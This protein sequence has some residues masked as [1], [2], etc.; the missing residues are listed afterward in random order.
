[1][2]WWDT[3][4]RACFSPGL[5]IFPELLTQFH[6][7][8]TLLFPDTLISTVKFYE[9]AFSLAEKR[10]RQ[11]YYSAGSVGTGAGWP[12][13]KTRPGN[14]RV[15]FSVRS[16]P[17]SS[18]V[19]QG[20]SCLELAWSQRDEVSGGHFCPRLQV[21]LSIWHSFMKKWHY[22][23]RI[24]SFQLPNVINMPFSLQKI[25]GDCTIIAEDWTGQGPVAVP[26]KKGRKRA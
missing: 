11:H 24:R 17:P 9:C 15:T 2:S 5:T 21:F 22:C 7:K 12:F 20:V 23:F 16:S 1:M 10:G 18:G 25:E 8:M 3:P 6:E 14:C 13:K 19:V 26:D 4:N